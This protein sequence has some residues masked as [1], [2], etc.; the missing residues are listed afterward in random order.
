M[1][2]HR[3]I[4]IGTSAGGIGAL[5][6]VLRGLPAKLPASI[7]VVMH[8]TPHLPSF[9]DQLL[10]KVTRLHVQQVTEPTRFYPGS[11]YVAS[12][13]HHLIL[14]RD[15]VTINR[16]PR[17]NWHRPSVD[18]LF[19]SAATSHGPHVI[20]TVLTGFLDDGTA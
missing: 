7:F 14:G 4:V 2:G 8:L 10:R 11:V 3:I 12:P 17:E 13:D 6:E 18:V 5:Q 1:A 15:V 20:G 16:G 19:R 9:L